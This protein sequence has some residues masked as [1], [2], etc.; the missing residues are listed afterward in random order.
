MMSNLQRP[1]VD[2]YE[3]WSG[4]ERGHFGECSLSD[5]EDGASFGD[6]GAFAAGWCAAID[7]AVQEADRLTY[8]LDHGGNVYRRPSGADV[9]AG[10]LRALHPIATTGGKGGA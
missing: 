9:V 2:A 3:D 1:V 5:L 10:A 6:F 7:A 8:A 4:V